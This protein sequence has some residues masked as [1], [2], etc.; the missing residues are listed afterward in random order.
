MAIG[1]GWKVERRGGRGGLR[2]L[3]GEEEGFR[4]LM[5]E[6]EGFGTGG[7]VGV[8]E[9]RGVGNEVEG[10]RE[11]SEEGEEVLEISCSTDSVSISDESSS[12][13][14]LIGPRSA[15]IVICGRD[16]DQDGRLVGCEVGLDQSGHPRRTSNRRLPWLS[17]GQPE[18]SS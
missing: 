12:T 2:G 8:E 14:I 9:A 1:V 11:D 16:T 6:K 5:E 18:S 15:G 10:E 13:L 3:V 7:G 17:T 4:G